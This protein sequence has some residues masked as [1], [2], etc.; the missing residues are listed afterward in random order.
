MNNVDAT[1]QLIRINK[2]VLKQANICKTMG[3]KAARKEPESPDVILATLFKQGNDVEEA[4]I[5]EMGGGRRMPSK[6]HMAAIH[7]AAAIADDSTERILQPVFNINGVFIRPDE[8]D[9]SC[10]KMTEIK[11]SKQ[12]KNDHIIDVTISVL[13]TEHS[14][15]TVEQIFVSHLNPNYLIGNGESFDAQ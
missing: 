3:W 7:T 1:N 9:S 15:Y 11:S 12:V 10:T 8:I 13:G 6:L 14:G 4:A 2:F 5:V